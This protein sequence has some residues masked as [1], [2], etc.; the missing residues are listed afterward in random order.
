MERV[1][2]GF[3]KQVLI[4]SVVSIGLIQTSCGTLLGGRVQSCQKI[5]PGIDHRELRPW[6]FAG[7]LLL[8]PVALPID[9][10]TGAIYKPCQR[11]R[12]DVI[13]KRDVRK[14]HRDKY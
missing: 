5:K 8:A 11:Y 1:R 13:N 2:K 10:S 9:F 7:D 14:M 4:L 12:V 3:R 6:A